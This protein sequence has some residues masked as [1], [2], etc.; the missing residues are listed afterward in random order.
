MDLQI[1]RI[2]H[3]SIPGTFPAESIQIDLSLPIEGHPLHLQQTTLEVSPRLPSP[4]AY[5]PMITFAPAAARYVRIESTA[6]NNGSQRN[7]LREFE[8]YAGS[9]GPPPAATPVPTATP[10]DPAP[11][12]TP[13]PPPTATPVAGSSMH[14]GDLVA[15]SS[16][17]ARSRW[18]A[19][20]TILVHDE[21]EAPVGGATVSGSWSQGASGDGTC[22]TD[23]DGMCSITKS[24]LKS[25]VSSVTF[26]IETVSHATT[27]YAPGLNHDLN[28]NGTSVVVSQP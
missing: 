22:V 12:Q 13:V 8:I 16:P 14:V 24:K 21:R 26:T 7:R 17:A 3:A 11:T 15:A 25:N 18:N 19:S 28:G 6:W 5:P 20:V 27:Q 4:C 1:P 9:G 2:A 10:T 23:S